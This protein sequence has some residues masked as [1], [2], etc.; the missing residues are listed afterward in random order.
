MATRT[1]IKLVDLGSGQGALKE[2]EAGDTLPAA[3]LP[4]TDGITEG[5]TNLFFTE[6]RVRAT[7]MTG[8]STAT[9]TAVVATDTLLVAVGKL[10]AQTTNRAVKGANS[11][12]T[13]LSGLTTPLSVS[14]GGTGRTDGSFGD[15]QTWQDLTASRATGTTYTNTSGKALVLAGILGPTSGAFTI[16]VATV[17]GVPIYS[18]YAGVAGNYVAFNVVVPAGATYS[19]APSNGTAVLVNWRE[20]RA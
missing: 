15:S 10:Q 20:M 4:T 8:L 14:Q 16:A 18:T 9:G 5:T 12:I 19:V 3:V 7:P 1:P 11:D 6:P 17:G 13:S 2:F